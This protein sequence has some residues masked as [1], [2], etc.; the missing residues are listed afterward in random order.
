M[1]NLKSLPVEER[2]A[3]EYHPL[4]YR[5]EQTMRS[6]EDHIQ[7]F[8][9]L[10]SALETATRARRPGVAKDILLQMKRSLGSALSCFVYAQ[11]VQ[12]GIDH[13]HMR[14]VRDE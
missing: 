14:V 8:R 11:G 12:Y 4:K 3:M 13:P 1:T 7:E 10:Q 5:F 6:A 9:D 2:R